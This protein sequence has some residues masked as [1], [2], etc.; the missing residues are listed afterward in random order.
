MKTARL[1][2]VAALSAA[3]LAAHA[4]DSWMFRSGIPFESTLTRA[5]VQA[6]LEQ[7]RRE[8]NVYSSSY[9][10]LTNFSSQL[11]REQVRAEFL[12][13]R[14]GVAAMTGE[15]SGSAYLAARKPRADSMHLA[16]TPSN[17]Q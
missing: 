9:N 6:G 8:P 16:G 17:A 4:D 3:A 13:S 1:A 11:T 2:L 15:D 12:D 10:P 7:S 14:E 5:Q